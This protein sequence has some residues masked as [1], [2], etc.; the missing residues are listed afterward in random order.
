MQ[1][2]FHFLINKGPERVK[3]TQPNLKA[4]T[5]STP[6]AQQNNIAIDILL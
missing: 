2:L 3:A 1:A 4:I 5:T 6:L